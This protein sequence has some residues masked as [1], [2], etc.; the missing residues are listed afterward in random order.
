MTVEGSTIANYLIAHPNATLE[1]FVKALQTEKEEAKKAE[2]ER[3][4]AEREYFR[5][6]YLG[7][8]VLIEFHS[9]AHS[10][11][12]PIPDEVWNT[13]MVPCID[14]YTNTSKNGTR[15]EIDSRPLNYHWLDNPYF[16]HTPFS[17]GPGTKCKIITKKEFDGVKELL[18][19]TISL[20][21]LKI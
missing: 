6:H 11:M 10:F 13:K 4:K 1:E 18:E 3:Y 5:E 19:N 8:Y 21:P 7:K 20:I 12:G 16:P 9:A 14:V 15:I 17:K 2:D